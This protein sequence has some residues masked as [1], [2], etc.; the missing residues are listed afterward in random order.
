[1]SE[2]TRDFLGVAELEGRT[3]YAAKTLYN[4]HSSGTGPLAE[5]LTKLGGKVGAWRAD[6]E[7]WI[8]SQRRLKDA[9]RPR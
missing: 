5:I 6:Y 2:S 1:M 4:S 8:E 3:G 9:E 7:I